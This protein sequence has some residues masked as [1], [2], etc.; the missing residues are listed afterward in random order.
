MRLSRFALLTAL[1]FFLVTTF[2]I[3]QE[4]TPAPPYAQAPATAPSASA[5]P[6]VSSGPLGRL[7][8]GPG[9]EGDVSVYGVPE[10]AQHVRVT[11]TGEIDLPLVGQRMVAGMTAE[12]A[13]AL[14]GKRLVEGGAVRGSQD[15]LGL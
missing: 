15:S 4:P 6:M 10:L 12:E 7:L 8:I 3:A 11:E 2:S 14:N 1:I 9:D 13:E 5:A